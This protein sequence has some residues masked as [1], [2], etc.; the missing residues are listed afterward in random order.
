MF[1]IASLQEG[2][3]QLH[4]VGEVISPASGRDSFILTPVCHPVEYKYKS[5]HVYNMAT[6]QPSDS[7]STKVANQLKWSHVSNTHHSP[8]SPSTFHDLDGKCNKIL[9]NIKEKSCEFR[10]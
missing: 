5:C 3:D 2:W 4:G 7:V 10:K 6:L 8:T 1:T 9:Q